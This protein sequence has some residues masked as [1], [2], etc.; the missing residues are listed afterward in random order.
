[1]DHSLHSPS[2]HPASPRLGRTRGAFLTHLASER[3]VA[4]STQTQAL[5]GLLFLYSTVL[6]RPGVGLAVG[7]SS[8][9]TYAEPGIGVIRGHHLHESAVQRAARPTSR[10]GSP[11]IL[12]VTPSPP[13]RS[14]TARTSGPSSGCSVTGA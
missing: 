4:V 2:R 6:G 11:V 3:H 7:L 12:F 14:K 5:Y 1:M 9:R 8:G 10:S 13:T